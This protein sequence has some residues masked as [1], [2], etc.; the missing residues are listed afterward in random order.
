MP[1]YKTVTNIQ[2]NLD[3]VLVYS[4]AAITLIFFPFSFDALIIPKIIILFAISAYLV[5]MVFNRLRNINVSKKQR[6]LLIL[7]P[8]LVLSYLV[9][10]VIV[11]DAPF[12]QQIFGRTGRGLGFITFFSLIIFTLSSIVF[13]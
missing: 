1:Y 3:M 10:I 2:K 12:E 5:P 6:I 13:I 8:I 11:S 9:L 7:I 4:A